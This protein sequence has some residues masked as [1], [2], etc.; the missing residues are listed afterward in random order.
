M[1]E[2]TVTLDPPIHH[3]GGG[4]AEVRVMFLNLRRL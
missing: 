1:K 3:A 2:L 4:A